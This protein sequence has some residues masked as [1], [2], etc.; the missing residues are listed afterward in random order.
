MEKNI[1]DFKDIFMV[2]KLIKEETSE[3]VTR[4]EAKSEAFEMF[5]QLD[6]NAAIYPMSV[7]D[8]FVMALAWTLNLDGTADTGY[9][10]Q[11]EKESLADY[12]EYV[13][14]GKLYMISEEKEGTSNEKQGTSSSKEKEGTSDESARRIVKLEIKASFGG[15]LMTLKG[16]PS[17]MSKFELDQTLF[18]LIKKL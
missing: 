7:G 5:M 16:S 18:L 6:M 4:I 17:Y 15:L 12:Y 8:R 1:I 13:M 9:Y 14:R 11:E 2:D 10:T 3:T